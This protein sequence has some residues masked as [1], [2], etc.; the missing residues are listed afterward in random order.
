[1]KK[2]NLV[3]VKP[4][5]KERWHGLHKQNRAKFQGT[6]DVIQAIYDTSIGR[7]ATGLSTKDEERLS[8]ILGVDLSPN[9][10]NE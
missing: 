3:Y 8:G 10:S 6:A 7:L 5:I 2:A 9:S 4:I 1:M